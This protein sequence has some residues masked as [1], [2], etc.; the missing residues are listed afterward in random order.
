M[1]VSL[2]SHEQARAQDAGAGCGTL[3][4]FCSVPDDM[5]GTVPEGM[6]LEEAATIGTGAITAAMG[7]FGHLKID[8]QYVVQ[9]LSC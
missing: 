3:A 9:A 2:L 7:L 8:Q 5:L 6:P 4:E 1:S